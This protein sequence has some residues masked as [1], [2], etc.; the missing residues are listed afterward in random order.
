MDIVFSNE[1]DRETCNSQKKLERKFRGNNRRADLVRRRLDELRDAD[2]LEMIGTIPQA[3]CHPLKGN[4]EGQFAVVLDKGYRMIFVPAHDPVPALPGGG[5]DRRRVTAIE[6]VKV[7][8]DY[9]D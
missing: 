1:R 8:E 9:H 7:A 4:R 3:R 6:V 5:I 2:N